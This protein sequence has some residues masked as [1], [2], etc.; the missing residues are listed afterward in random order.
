MS[1]SHIKGRREL[2]TTHPLRRHPLTS[3]QQGLKTTRLL[4]LSGYLLLIHLPYL[5]AEAPFPLFSLW[6]SLVFQ[7]VKNPP[8][9]QETWV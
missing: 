1:P 9:M 6:A 8:A 3:A 4:Y 7:L 5:K 2:L